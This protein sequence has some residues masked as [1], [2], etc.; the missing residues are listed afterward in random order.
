MKKTKSSARKSESVKFE[1]EENV[2]DQFED[3]MNQSG[4]GAL[5]KK[6]ASHKP[7][8]TLK[9][10]RTDNTVEFIEDLD[11][12]E[13]LTKKPLK[14]KFAGQQKRPKKQSPA[15]KIAKDFLPDA[16]IDLHG[17]TQSSALT[18]VERFMQNSK[19]RGCKSLLIITG[20][21]KNSDG[22]RGV[23]KSTIWEWL[24]N[25]Q[26]INSIRFQKAPDFLGGDGAVLVFI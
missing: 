10:Q 22:N 3:L 12:P 14:G 20:R 13:K 19:A 18:R 15:K 6:S 7:K 9:K 23:L 21:G 8:K 11:W 16:T 2:S 24:K 26:N 17:E 5:S 25:Q 1:S 4:V